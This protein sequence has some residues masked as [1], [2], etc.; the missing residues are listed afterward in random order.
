MN[1]NKYDGVKVTFVALY[2]NNADLSCIHYLTKPWLGEKYPF[3]T[4]E[5]S[6]SILS[7]W[8]PKN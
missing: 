1:Y 8:Y 3:T 4:E 7:I 6:G 5:G 2:I